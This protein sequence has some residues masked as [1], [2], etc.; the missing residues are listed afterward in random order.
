MESNDLKSTPPDDAQLENWLR[1]NAALPP[2]PDDGFSHRVLTALPTPQRSRVSLRLLVIGIGAVAGLGFAAVKF[3]TGAPV[4][5]VLP[6]VGPEFAGTLAQLTD[7]K[8]HVA[9][10][11]TLVTLVCVFWPDLRRRVGL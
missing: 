7:P 9:L 11:V 3:A 5:F 10:G 6:A 1:T 4:E 8:L 2:L